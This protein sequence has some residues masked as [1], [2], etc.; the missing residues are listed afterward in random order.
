MKLQR[1]TEATA[2]M[3]FHMTSDTRVVRVL[4]NTGTPLTG[5]DT[6]KYTLQATPVQEVIKQRIEVFEEDTSRNPQKFK[7]LNLINYSS[8]I[9]VPVDSFGQTRYGVFLFHDE[10]GHFTQEH[11]RQARVATRF[12]GAIIDRGEVENVV[13]RVQPLVFAGQI[14]STLI[15]ELNN[16]LGSVLNYAET[17][18]VEHETLEKDVSAAMDPRF[19]NRIRTCVANLENNARGMEKITSLYLGLMSVGTREVVSVNE[20]VQR[21][22]SVL[23]PVAER[24]HV[25][26]LTEL[27]EGLPV[28]VAVGSWL[29]QA[30]VNVAL[31]AIQNISLSKTEG[32][33]VVQTRFAKHDETLSIQVL[34]ID[35]GPGIHAQHLEHIFNLG[36]STRTEGTGLGLF[37]TRGII[38]ALSGKIRVQTSIMLVG[39]TFLVELPL[40]VPS[41]E[42]LTS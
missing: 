16:R 1:E 35:N 26:I 4:V 25:E 6:N 31:N 29:E 37:T 34:F 42:E 39:T 36:F 8:C 27:E 3:L 13:R 28:T 15:H 21:A 23:A 33:L 40:I 14:G 7:Y 19:R 10:K 5:Y 17:L 18:L 9:G 2:C 38:E 12:I 20:T 11:L 41:V 24:N 30:F 32:E 22:L